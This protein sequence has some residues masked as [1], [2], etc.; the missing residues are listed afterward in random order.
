MFYFLRYVTKW[1]N[2]LKKF[3]G[4]VTISVYSMEGMLMGLK[5][6]D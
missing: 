6:T 3:N 4:L 5:I 2:C 1:A